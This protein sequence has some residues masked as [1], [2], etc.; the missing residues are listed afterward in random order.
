[1]IEQERFLVSSSEREKWL[2]VRQQGV[3]AT[4]VSKAV[5]PDGYR[6][7]LDQLRRPTDIPDNDYMRFGREQEGPIIEKLQSLVDIQPNDWLI[8]RDTAE[9]KWM[10]ATPDGLSSNHEVIAEVKTT[11]RDWERWAKVPGNYHRQVQWQLFVTGAEVCIFAWMLRV[12]KG[13][14]MEPAW[15]GPKFLE[16]TRDEVLIERLQETAHRL[17]GDL[18]AI[19]S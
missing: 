7:V 17:Y 14:V 13:S 4:A 2:E 6:E 10:M 8:S 16:V 15:P 5:T 12:K 11:G 1:M 9:K 18:L 19:R 3:T